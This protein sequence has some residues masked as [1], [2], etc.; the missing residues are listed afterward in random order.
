MI[1]FLPRRLGDEIQMQARAA[2]P[3]ECC[4]LIEGV[5]ENADIRVTALHATRNLANEIGHFEIDPAQHIALLRTL[6]GTGHEIVGC[7]HSHPGGEAMPSARDGAG[8]FE[9]D[10]VWLIAAVNNGDVSLAGF[11]SRQTGFA[12]LDLRLA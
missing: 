10:F 1:L 9:T 6:R 12:P 4:G 7:Y 3:R 2:A 11:I 8:A 5:R